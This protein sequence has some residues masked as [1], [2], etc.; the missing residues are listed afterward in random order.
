MSGIATAIIGTGVISAGASIFGSKEAAKAAEKGA[1]EATA[2]ELEM[3]Y[4]SREDTAPW[5]EAG[6]QALN[7]LSERIAAGPGEFRPEEDPGYQ[8]GYKEFVEKPLLRG[9]AAGGR[10]GG[11]R[12]A[13]EL[14]RYASDYGTT[15][16]DQFLDR[17]YRSL[18]PYQS[19]AQ[20]GQTSAERA[21]GGALTTGRSVGQNILSG[22]IARGTGYRQTG[23]AISQLAGG[24]G[25]S[26]LDHFYMS[27]YLKP[28]TP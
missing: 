13:K 3:Y 16:Y 27:K 7:V 26:A 14:T 17:W 21:A 23:E 12:T 18:T 11:G 9:A 22:G 19:L 4:Q 2:A 10:L 28:V 24:L 1:D 20:V 25:Q 5:R 6:E 8:F 15:K